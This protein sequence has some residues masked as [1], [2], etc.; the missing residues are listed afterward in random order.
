MSATGSTTIA[1]RPPS[2]TLASSTSW[3]T[4]T[5]STAMVATTAMAQRIGTFMNSVTT[6]IT[7]TASVP[8]P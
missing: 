3:F 6:T 5:V 8:L 2:S 1:T 4:S 7:A